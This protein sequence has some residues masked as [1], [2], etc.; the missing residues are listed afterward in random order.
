VQF[1]N[2]NEITTANDENV[3]LDHFKEIYDLKNNNNLS[4]IFCT[5]N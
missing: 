1:E 3:G 4:K 5:L 2:H